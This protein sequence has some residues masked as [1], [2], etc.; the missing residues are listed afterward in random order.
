MLSPIAARRGP[1]EGIT[2]LMRAAPFV[3][4]P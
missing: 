4:E 2:H 1:H 3:A